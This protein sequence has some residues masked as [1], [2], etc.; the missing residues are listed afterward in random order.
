[1]ES[2]HKASGIGDADRDVCPA[3]PCT[4]RGGRPAPPETGSFNGRWLP[5]H[6]IRRRESFR[7]RKFGEGAA[8]TQDQFVRPHAA[9]S[10]FSDSLS[11]D[12]SLRQDP[13]NHF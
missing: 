9:R 13:A 8:G 3:D 4:I 5:T 6:Q 1:M 7:N 12:P 10:S 2:G 11:G